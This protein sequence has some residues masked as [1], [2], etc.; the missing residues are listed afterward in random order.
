[1]H[2]PLGLAKAV[3]VLAPDQHRH[4]LDAR[5]FAGQRIFHL[6]SQPRDSAQR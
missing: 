6:H 1:M 5:A 4:A 3:G 2:A